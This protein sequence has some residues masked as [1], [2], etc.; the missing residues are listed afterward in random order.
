M[1]KIIETTITE[2]TRVTKDIYKLIVK[3]DIDGEPGQFVQVRLP[4]NE[5]TLR[6]P[7]GIAAIENE[8]LTMFY[9]IVGQG[10]KFL[11]T[12][13][14]GDPINILAPLGNNFDV[15]GEKILLV[16]GGLGLAPLLFAASKSKSADVE[17]KSANT[18]KTGEKIFV[19]V[20]EDTFN[21]KRNLEIQLKRC[22][23]QL[24]T[25]VM[26]IMAL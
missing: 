9:R 6:R 20:D 25:E 2:N 11:S 26:V 22:S 19:D 14:G 21:G 16:G 24:M 17:K 3:A 8:Q 13:K 18:V 7:L 15:T 10:T 23:L 4:S 5:F 1:K 12:C